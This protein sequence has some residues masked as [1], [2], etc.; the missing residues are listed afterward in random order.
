MIKESRGKRVHSNWQAM[1]ALFTMMDINVVLG[2]TL[3]I[4]H[5]LGVGFSVHSIFRT[6]TSQG[7][8]AWAISLNTVPYIAVPLYVVFGKNRFHGY[9]KARNRKDIELNYLV[10]RMLADTDN[11]KLFI[12]VEDARSAVMAYLA[13]IPF[14]VG[15]RAK[16]LIDGTETF[17]AIF[18]AI[19]SAT[20][21]ILIQFFVVEND[22]LGKLLKS[23]L[24]AKSRQGV[25]VYFIYDE[26]G[27][28]NLS[29]AYSD[30]LKRGGVRITPFM[31][32]RGNRNRFQLNFRNHRKTVV[33]DGRVAFVGG[34]NVGDQYLGLNPKFGHWRDTHVKVEGPAVQGIQLCF[35][36]DW[37]WAVGDVPS[38]S[39][40]PT[41]IEE[42]GHATL[43]V[44]SGPAD[45]FETC[46][47]LFLNAINGAEKRIWIA[48]PY[49]VPDNSIVKALQLAALKGVDVRVILPQK[50]DH[51]LVHLSAFSYI[52]ETELSGVKFYSYQYG[53][54]HQKVMLV[55][56]DMATIGTANFDNRS[57]RLNFEMTLLFRSRS[58]AGEVEEM[59]KKDFE[60]CNLISTADYNS[61]PFWYKL[62]IRLSRLMAPLQ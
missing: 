37:F 18:E 17:D 13:G 46:G 48:S 28:Y 43:V 38:L 53:F 56:D 24:L 23:K 3:A 39:W 4:A 29:S 25:A 33:V 42:R 21:Y 60:N 59:L 52:N 58:F 10:S 22:D 8:I 61:K 11:N 7:A 14:T 5:V 16:L 34:H 9:I 15:N 36:E 44:G 40:Q 57:F 1:D 45:N 50:P 51:L 12:E 31:T 2:I 41:L 55:D 54:M 47:L 26:I 32:T 6:H 27:S 30:E 35:V 20:D 19:D 62:A 49:F